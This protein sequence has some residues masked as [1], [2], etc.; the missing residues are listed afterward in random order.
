MQSVQYFVAV[1]DL[2]E[3]EEKALWDFHASFD[4]GS[5]EKGLFINKSTDVL[6]GAGHGVENIK[7]GDTTKL[8]KEAVLVVLRSNTFSDFRFP[9]CVFGI[10]KMDIPTFAPLIKRCIRSVKKYIVE[11][12]GLFRFLVCDGHSTHSN[13][14]LA[15]KSIDGIDFLPG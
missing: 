2:N 10:E 5:V 9:L 7:I 8:V 15:M 11:R 14:L 13:P 6:E 4:G 1:H 3:E 12:K